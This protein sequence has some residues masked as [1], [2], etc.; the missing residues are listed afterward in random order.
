MESIIR[1]K[2]FYFLE[3]LALIC[4]HFWARCGKEMVLG[5]SLCITISATHAA[6]GSESDHSHHKHHNEALKSAAGN[7]QSSTVSISI[8]ETTLTDQNGQRVQVVQDLIGNKVVYLTT[9]YTNCTTICTPIGANVAKLQR[10]LIDRIGQQALENRVA[11]LTVSIDPVVDTPQRLNAWQ[12]K[13]NGL[14][15]WTLL[16]GSQEDIDRLLKATGLFTAE[17]E[18]HSPIGL[19]GHIESDQWSRVSSLA[20]PVEIAQLILQQL[21][22][23]SASVSENQ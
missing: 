21:G 15:G 3:K 4:I 5:L 20:P 13:F 10:T 11:L 22:V 18:D 8:P 17:P 14:P 2:L 16:T 7:T 12:K 19:V 9:I 1:S 6:T 23:D